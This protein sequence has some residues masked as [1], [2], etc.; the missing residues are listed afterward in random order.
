MASDGAAVADAI[1]NRE[2]EIIATSHPEVPVGVEQVLRRA[3][4]KLPENRYPS[5]TAFAADLMTLAPGADSAACGD[6][7][8]AIRLRIRAAG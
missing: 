2:P 1:L 6:R 4:A 3:L 5:M 8:C 7:R